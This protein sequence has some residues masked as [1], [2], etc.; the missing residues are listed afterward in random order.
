MVRKM[1]A[2]LAA[3][4]LIAGTVAPGQVL[5]A[6][7][8]GGWTS[9][10]S[11]STQRPGSE[12][13]V[14]LTDGR[15][16]VAGASGDDYAGLGNVDIYDPAHGWSL[17]PHLDGDPLGVVASP[18]PNGSALIAGGTPFLGGFDGPG[19][20]PVAKAMTY[21]PASSTWKSAPSMSRARNSATATPLADGRVLVTGGY[22][23][24]VVQLP[25]PD[26]QPFC[27]LRID[28]TALA[29]SEMFDAKTSS[30]SSAGNLG[31]ARY[32]HQAVT[33]MDGKVLVV[34]GQDQ[35]G[36]P[37]AY[38]ASAELFDPSTGTWAGAGDIEAPR[39]GFTLTALADGRALLAG[40]LA[41]DGVTVL[42]S[43]LLYDPHTNAWAQGPDMKDART[44]HG[45]AL[46]KDG[47]VLVTGGVDKLGRLATSEIF[48]AA[49]G[50]WITTGA[51]RT[52]RS[53]AV[54][55]PL[56][57]GRVLV[58]GGRGSKTGLADS[59]I[60]DPNAT[61]AFP[62]PR[63]VVGPGTWAIKPTLPVPS[64]AQ[65]LRLLKDGRVLMLS[66][67]GYPG[68][69]A[70]IYDPRSATWTTSFTRTSDQQFTAGT[71][72]A[73]D[74]VLLVTLDSEGLKPAK[75]EVI[76]PLTGAARAAVSPGTLGSARLD[77][78]PDGRV[79]LTGGPAGDKRSLF[80]D[81]SADRWSPGPDVPNDLY[82]GTVTWIP[83][84][85][86]LV[87][88]ILKAM[89]LDPRSGQ[90]SEARGFPGRWNSYSAT[91]L[92]NGDVL[93][94]GGTEDQMQT[95]G[96][97]LSV[98]TTRVMRWN[99]LTGLLERARDMT[100]PRPFHS[101]VV[102]RDGRV[103]FAGGIAS[104]DSGSDPV[105][106]AELYDPVKDTWSS[107]QSLPEAR[108]QMTGVLLPDGTVLEVGGWALFNPARTMAYAP[109]AMAKPAA[110]VEANAPLVALIKG[111]LILL[112][113]GLISWALVAS[114]RRR[115]GSARLR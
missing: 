16:L 31:H 6:A 25:N 39:S 2:P 66:G 53:D 10:G 105:S 99:H 72:L 57:G 112:A 13:S 78:L 86:V 23:R 89:V 1:A 70:Q 102:L 103:L 28:I 42:R 15:V 75:A 44:E 87:G 7:P 67:G 104:A 90:W 111:L 37:A 100:A 101:T 36:N 5:A 74:R 107:A 88:G 114:A 83:G 17:G 110:T 27:C 115:N 43:T 26:Q 59:E 95:D 52:A 34:G 84:G 30:W 81:A 32:G 47:R 85:R 71:A 98:G 20:D 79:W 19:P 97:L 80:Y 73:D 93:L 82:V 106:T 56:H 12:L 62:V 11:L 58:A 65:D 91:M 54:A 41:P 40:G 63:T 96:R 55:V 92:P 22:D 48:D 50:A 38:L 24:K 35:P 51:L 68:Y 9:A 109:E 113:A 60:F 3:A 29:T 46:L 49:T 18:L 21:D 69:V 33:L 4:W 94:A 8:T 64:Y 45:A 76:D 61:G 14:L 77:L 108:S